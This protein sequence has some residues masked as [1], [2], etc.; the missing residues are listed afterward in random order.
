MTGEKS[1]NHKK[2]RKQQPEGV[3]ELLKKEDMPGK[4]VQKSGIRARE[5]D[6]DEN[7]FPKKQAA[8]GALVF[9]AILC[10][11]GGTR[12]GEVSVAVMC[13]IILI[14]L[15]MGFFLGNAPVFVT[16][17]LTAL[18]VLAGMF[19]TTLEIVALGC[20]VFIATVFVVKEK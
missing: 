5:E 10:I 11:I 9:L 19:T 16:V 13:V 15:L 14:V 17:I 3:T 6:F 20:I 18:M 8:L 7:A 4:R 1:S 2:K 12:I